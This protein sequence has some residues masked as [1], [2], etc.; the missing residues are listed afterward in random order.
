[1]TGS[2]QA[3]EQKI[4]EA[5]AGFEF[6]PVRFSFVQVAFLKACIPY[7]YV[8]KRLVMIFLSLSEK[9]PAVG[10]GVQAAPPLQGLGACGDSTQRT[11]RGSKC[12][13][14]SSRVGCLSRRL[15]VWELL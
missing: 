5:K 8:I 11:P 15:S 3:I 4:R 6:I 14:W 12:K 1:M 13:S 7:A 10:R 2:T 9:M